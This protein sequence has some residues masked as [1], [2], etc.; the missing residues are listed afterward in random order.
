MV[1]DKT[2]F[3]SLLINDDQHDN[4]GVVHNVQDKAV[5]IIMPNKICTSKT[6][7]PY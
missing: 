6:V 3:S 2:L 1:C 7:S 4:Y 5:S